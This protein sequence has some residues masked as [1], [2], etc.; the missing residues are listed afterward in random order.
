MSFDQ[1]VLSI[2]F[3]KLGDFQIIVWVLVLNNPRHFILNALCCMCV[4]KVLS[5]VSAASF[6]CFS[7]RVMSFQSPGALESHTGFISGLFLSSADGC[8]FLGP[9]GLPR[10][11]PKVRGGPDE[12]W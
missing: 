6:L 7:I 11:V 4:T 12:A 9:L 5:M 2:S 3:I 8:R 10:P 1:Y